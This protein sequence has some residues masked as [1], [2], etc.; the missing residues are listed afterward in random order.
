MKGLLAISV[1]PGAGPPPPLGVG[2]RHLPDPASAVTDRSGDDRVTLTG[3]DP[4]DRVPSRS[5]GPLTVRLTRSV[6]ARDGDLATDR[7]A[8]LLGDG[9]TLDGTAL[10]RILPPFAAAHRPTRDR[11]LVLVG[12]WLGFRH[13]YWWQGDGMA[14]V[15][16]SALALAEVAGAELNL[17]A[18]GVQSL[19]G[20]QVGVDTVFQ[21]VSKLPPGC[22]AVL[23]HGRVELR[24]YAE[25]SLTTEAVPSDLDTVI[26]EMAEILREVVGG[27]VADHPDTLLQLSG[28][29]D[30]RLVLSAVPPHLRT[31]LRALTLDT[32][33]GVES[34]IAQR[35]S[36]ACGLAHEIEWLDERPPAAPPAAYRAAREAATAQ[37]A[38]SSPL[39]LAPLL[40]IEAG[41]EQGRRL[42]GVG[43]E[44]ARGFY[45]PGQPR[46][47]TTSAN[48]V[49]RLAEWRLFP[50]EAVETAALDPDFAAAAP[51]A[52]VTAVGSCFDQYHPDW[53]RATD[54]FYL[55]QRVQ[56]WA[57]V[58]ASAVSTRR[59]SVDPLLDR[60][61]MQCALAPAPADKRRSQLT[62][63]LM[64]RLSPELAAIPLDSGLVPA[65]LAHPSLANSLA[66]RRVTVTK[67]GRKVW[68]RVRR[69]RRAQLGA[70]DLGRLVQARWREAPEL[71]AP[72]RRTGLVRDGWLDELLDGRRE[73]RPSTVAFLV[74]LLVAAEVNTG[75]GSR[76]PAA[77]ATGR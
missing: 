66:L 20:W 33:G 15:S 17:A 5:P 32:H 75:P 44:T 8:A 47:A 54:E 7:L 72:I 62:G 2:V 49:R 3:P 74:N 29:Q 9:T 59:Y 76:V 41:V 4:G 48:L 11:A 52:A 40:L 64:H 27:C 65:R 16:T 12:D 56:R 51:A 22:A 14:A 38:T 55:W 71:V 39:A 46:H 34:R 53:L 28:G 63:R 68:Q 31:G 69:A 57:G 18:L 25:A 45:Y 67:T 23:Q 61:F 1:A 36:E 77:Q 60:G 73:A 58:H 13:L 35:L 37:D 24:R 19:L 70:A 21:R 26:E 6:R 30:S 43:G 50:N 42:S 10:C